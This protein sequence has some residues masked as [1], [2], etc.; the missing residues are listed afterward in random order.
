MKPR[1]R[2]QRPAGD[3][4]DSA[5]RAT[6]LSL[7]HPAYLGAILA[8]AASLVLSA[9]YRLYDTDLWTLLVT[10]KAIWKSGA[11]PIILVKSAR[12]VL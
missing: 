1:G 8:C 5:T 9:S 10:G 4:G 6:P 12:A 2:G 3:R 11:I 7:R